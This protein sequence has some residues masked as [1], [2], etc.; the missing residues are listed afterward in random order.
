MANIMEY[1]HKQQTILNKSHSNVKHQGI[2]PTR[3]DNIT[4]T[5]IKIGHPLHNPFL[6][7]KKK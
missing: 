7:L 2:K 3:K 1:A 4:I 5:R 6:P